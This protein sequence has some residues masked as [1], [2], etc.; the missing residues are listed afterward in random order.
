M[1]KRVVSLLLALCLVIGT[2]AVSMSG[3]LAADGDH[4]VTVKAGEHG[5]VS[6]DGVNWA[7]SVRV[8][9]PNGGKLIDSFK[10]QPDYGYEFDKAVLPAGV[11]T[12][13]AGRYFS[14]IIDDAGG[15]WTVGANNRGQLGRSSDTNVL[16]KVVIGTPDNKAVAVAAGSDHT[17]VLDEQ[18]R[19]WT[20]GG[21]LF[22]Q[23]G[24]KA[25]AN[26]MLSSQPY[27]TQVTDGIGDTKIVAIAAGYYSTVLLDENG[28][29]W[30]AGSNLRG[31][32]GRPENAG[33]TAG[34]NGEAPANPTFAQ[35]TGDIADVKAVGIASGLYHLI[36]LD[37]NGR[38][39][40][41][42]QKVFGMTGRTFKGNY[43]ATLAQ[44]AVGKDNAK[45]KAVY[46]EQYSSYLLD[47]S[48]NVWVAG[49]N[50]SGELGLSKSYGSVAK[51]TQVTDGLDGAM[52]T[53]VVP[54][55]SH[56]AL[57]DVDGNAYSAG[58]NPMGQLGRT[59]DA[60]SV[61][62]FTKITESVDGVRFVDGAAGG[63]HTLLKDSS[64]NLWSVGSNEYYQLDRDENKG[65]QKANYTFAKITTEINGDY[66]LDALKDRQVGGD[67]TVTIYFKERARIK[68][69]YKLR[70]GE[71]IDGYT[72][73]D[74]YYDGDSF[75]PPAADKLTKEGY[76]LT[77]WSSETNNGVVTYYA[78]WALRTY[79]VKFNT[80][81]G[82]EIPDKTEVLWFDK[83]LEGIETP[84]KQGYTFWFWSCDGMRLTADTAYRDIAADDTVDTIVLDAW[85]NANTD[86]PYTIEHWQQNIDDDGY[87]LFESEPSAGTTDGYTSVI[88]KEYTG[89]TVHSTINMEKI[90]GD[91]STVVKVYYYRNE[92]SLTWDAAGGTLGGDHTSGKVRYGAK[93]TAPTAAKQGYDF[94]GWDKSVPSTMPAEALKF[95]AEWTPRNDTPYAVEHWQQN[96]DDDG[97]TLFETVPMKG[98]TDGYTSA[99]SKGYDGFR[100]E[101][102]NNEKINGD[103]STVVKLY[104][105]RMSYYLTWDADGG[106][107]SGDYT[108]GAVRY[109]AKITAPTAEKKGYDFAGWGFDVPETMPAYGFHLTAIWTPRD[110]TPYTVEH[111]QRNADDDGFTLAESEP[112]TGTTDS[113]A[114]AEP[115]DYT[116]FTF[117]SITPEIISGDGSTVV[118]LYYERKEYD[119]VWNAD[120][121]VLSGD[122]TSGKVRYGAKIAAPTPVKKGYTFIGWDAEAP[123]TMPNENVTLTAQWQLAARMPD[124]KLVI[125]YK[126]V[127]KLNTITEDPSLI[128]YTSS[129]ESVV[130]VDKD[131]SYKAVGRGN[132]AITM[133]IIGT[134]IEEHCE[135]TVKYAWWQVLIR[136][137]LLGFIWY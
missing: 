29:V 40:T 12:V 129:D 82:T 22:G 112:L 52:I 131:G 63:Q 59:T 17:V 38:V 111:W 117:D 123:S 125:Y 54:G 85:W 120:G 93:I 74:F 91:G 75:T 65:T 71:W 49:S 128:E 124:R 100:L 126:S 48:G 46:A 11:S 113:A 33:S 45:I 36:V 50:S 56:I 77:Y 122:Y 2:A 102:I 109:G 9:V 13:A 103:G 21:N 37:E 30:T 4:T 55:Q 60:Q 105:D 101:E 104:Y 41:A 6:A 64:G 88:P 116:G 133:H 135:I 70:G 134:D 76:V 31:Q 81:G 3:V 68:V 51:F 78:N 8:T 87:T 20:A 25:G 137:F 18:G 62:G 98:T 96:A 106:V 110:D 136:I 83:V 15:V 107:L 79:T 53:A 119:L 34:T 44:A 47:E 118:K 27:F 94:S 92:Y 86:T 95:T 89:F 58:K 7:D 127:G 35:V 16:K 132:A 72:A 28:K 114:A 67:A 80:Y 5:K 26:G 73:P 66:S 121:G 42:G 10:Y 43:D 99:E 39:W 84:T 14:V 115:K 19:V 108:S 57:I 23:L 69:E 24:V 97:Y 130:T 32:L 61:Y 1:K 90:K